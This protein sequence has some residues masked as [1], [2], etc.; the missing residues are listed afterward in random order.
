M[1]RTQK[2]DHKIISIKPQRSRNRYN[3]IFESGDV[4]GISGD[5][6]LSR[7]LSEGEYISDK[8]LNKIKND[9][10]YQKIK[11]KIFRLLSYRARSRFELYT[12]ISAKGFDKPQ[13]SHVL[14][15]LEAKGYIDDSEFSKM[16]AM[17]LIKSKYLGRISVKYQFIKH[18]IPQE[19]LDP[20]LDELYTKY[21]IEDLIKKIINKKVD[22]LDA[23]LIN[24]KKLID[25]IKRKGYSWAEITTVINSF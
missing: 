14:D 22:I 13:V 18:Q 3:I 20:I 10:V 7:N 19:I 5:V 21:P 17:H 4:F 12:R 24:D 15:E 2:L 6:L 11:E 23:E 9:E 8:E 25:H 16:Y 1:G